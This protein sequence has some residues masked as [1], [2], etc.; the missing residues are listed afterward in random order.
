MSRWLRIIHARREII[1]QGLR[2]R[3]LNI[4]RCPFPF[5]QQSCKSTRDLW[6]LLRANKDQHDNREDDQMSKAQAKHAQK[7]ALLPKQV[8]HLHFADFG[9]LQVGIEEALFKQLPFGQT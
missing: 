4:A 8:E 7:V 6:Q 3:R 1:A 5:I 9:L 2:E